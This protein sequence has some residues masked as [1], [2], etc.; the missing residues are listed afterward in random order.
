ML[1]AGICDNVDLREALFMEDEPSVL[2]AADT[3]PGQQ[4]SLLFCATESQSV[5][6]DDRW[7]QARDEMDSTSELRVH[8]C[9]LPHFR[10]EI[11]GRP[12]RLIPH[13]L[14]M[15]L[16]AT[17]NHMVKD[18]PNPEGFPTLKAGDHKCVAEFTMEPAFV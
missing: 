10:P 17:E 4:Q 2:A 15:C 8:V 1:D 14:Q 5:S 18:H 3:K 13:L 12:A 11:P 9:E 6:D 7:P 16:Q